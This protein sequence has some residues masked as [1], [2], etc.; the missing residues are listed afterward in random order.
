MSDYLESADIAFGRWGDLVHRHRWAVLVL[1]IIALLLGFHF[2]GRAQVDNG[3]DSYFDPT[4]PTYSYYMGYQEDFGSDEVAYLLYA[5]PDK[6]H[7]PFDIDVMRNI[8]AL[9]RAFEDEVP[10]V[11]EVTS[12]TN[13]EFIHTVAAVRVQAQL[14]QWV[15]GRAGHFEDDG[16]VGGFSIDQ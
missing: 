15:A 16:G 5:A 7:G 6:P 10:F 14:V 13:V 9:T 4:D 3:L 12:L 1:A 2:A 11:R 8:D